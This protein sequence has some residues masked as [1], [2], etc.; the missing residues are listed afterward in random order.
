[1]SE[2]FEIAKRIALTDAARVR[3]NQERQAI[4]ADM[5]HLDDSDRALIDAAWNR[6]KAAAPSNLPASKKRES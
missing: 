3:A 6:H 4:A 2:W 1:M 5:A